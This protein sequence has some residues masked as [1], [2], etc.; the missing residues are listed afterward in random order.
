MRPVKQATRPIN[1]SIAFQVIVLLSICTV[2]LTCCAG[3]AI[4]YRKS[5][6][7]DPEDSSATSSASISPNSNSV[8]HQR[9][10]YTLQHVWHASTP[11]RHSGRFGNEHSL[12]IFH[13]WTGE[14]NWE[15]ARG[16]M[17]SFQVLLDS[18]GRERVVIYNIFFFF[19]EW[20]SNVYRF[21][22]IGW[23]VKYF[24]FLVILLFSLRKILLKFRFELSKV[25]IARRTVSVIVIDLRNFAFRI[26]Q[27]DLTG[28]C[29]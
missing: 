20:C 14:D 23:N 5:A 6:Y 26:F 13:D 12:I 2:F 19:R 9:E 27:S 29:Y 25:N 10:G 11:V 28:R 18:T 4:V 15:L 21:L 7:A 24:A 3:H 16:K 17:I 22:H 8:F 1:Q